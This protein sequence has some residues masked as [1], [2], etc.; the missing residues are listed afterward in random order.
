[1]KSGAAPSAGA[2]S[3]QRVQADP[4]RHRGAARRL[5]FSTKLVLVEAR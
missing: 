1:M 5:G 3:V 2:G 4:T